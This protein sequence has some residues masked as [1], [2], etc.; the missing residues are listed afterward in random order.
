MATNI[1]INDF[2]IN[3]LTEEQYKEAK[4]NNELN[5]DELYLTTNDIISEDSN[6]E[7]IIPYILYNNV[8][9]SNGNITLTDNI[10]NYTRIDVIY[11]FSG[12]RVTQT[13]YPEIMGTA[14]QSLYKIWRDGI[15]ASGIFMNW[16]KFSNKTITR[17][18]SMRYYYYKH[19]TK[20]TIDTLNQVYIYRVV[21]YK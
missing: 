15:N 17:V 10:D 9:G 20:P 16:Y 14:E 18:Q 13:F 12:S 2:K 6:D 21:G 7:A 4:A 19:E 3:Q 1:K 8:N 5:E 11:G